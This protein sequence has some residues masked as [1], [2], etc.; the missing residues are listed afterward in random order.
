MLLDQKLKFMTQKQ[1]RDKV[2]YLLLLTWNLKRNIETRKN[3]KIRYAHFTISITKN[4]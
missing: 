2:D 3:S 1:S 4:N